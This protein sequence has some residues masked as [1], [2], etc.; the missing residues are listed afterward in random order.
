MNGTKYYLRQILKC[1][2]LKV[3]LLNRKKTFA[4]KSFL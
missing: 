3:L 1:N 4:G 2:I